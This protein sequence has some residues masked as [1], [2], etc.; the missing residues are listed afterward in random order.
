[1]GIK[2]E[3]D[4]HSKTEIEALKKEIDE[5]KMALGEASLDNR[6]LK[7]KLANDELKKRSSKSSHWN[8]K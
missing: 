4:I 2:H 6:I 5:L 1:M 8:S 7:K 3:G